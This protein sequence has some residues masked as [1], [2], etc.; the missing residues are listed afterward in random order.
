MSSP[1]KPA[2]DSKPVVKDKDPH[3]YRKVGYSMIVISVSLVVI[4]LLSWDLADNYHFSSNIMA[5]QEVDS[6]TPKAGYNIVMFDI[7]QPVGAKLK[8]L[9]HAGTPDQATSMQSQDAQQNQGKTIQVLVVNAATDFTLH[10]KSDAEVYLQTPK[11]GYNI[12]LDNYPLAVGA[13]LTLA[14]HEVSLKN[15]TD[16]ETQQQDEIKGQEVHILIFTT[17]YTDNLKMVTGS[18]TPLGMYSLLASQT[19]EENATQSSENPAVQS[20]SENSTN[21]TGSQML[22]EVAPNQTAATLTNQSSALS[23]NQT[24]IPLENATASTNQSVA[25]VP[26]NLTASGIATANMPATNMTSTSNKTAEINE[27]NMGNTP[28]GNPTV[29]ISSGAANTK[30]TC[31]E[32]DCFNP[33]TISI[34][35]GDTVTWTNN[36]V[37]GHT[38]TSGK[39][40]DN[41]TGTVFDSG[42]INAGKSYTSPPF[43]TAGTYEY[44]C[45]VHPWM[46]GKI[47]VGGSEES[48]QTGKNGTATTKTIALNE[49]I[50][51]NATG[52]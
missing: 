34:S 13:Q 47:V 45:Q 28:Q 33:Q 2:D 38:A 32:S 20:V 44:F 5:L 15:A 46:T 10:L 23:N 14:S 29:I 49:T 17:K 30:G 6:M 7:S 25:S 37:A 48:G 52:K 18:S 16:Y 12:I 19:A 8:L 24:S 39:M 35:V 11:S 22:N 26:A 21:A 27:S 41:Q 3:N 9:D 51:V 31:T 43:E 4:A 42:L 40:T 50:N 1:P 36:D